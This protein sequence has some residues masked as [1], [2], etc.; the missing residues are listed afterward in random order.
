VQTS[1]LGSQTRI[2]VSCDAVDAPLT[3]AEFGRDRAVDPRLTPDREVA[4]W[5]DKD[6]AVLL[7]EESTTDEE[8]E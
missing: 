2:A 1:F 5:W 6:D 3:A 7:P 4:L 8:E